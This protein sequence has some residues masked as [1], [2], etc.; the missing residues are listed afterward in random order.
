MIV[1]ERRLEWHRH[2]PR[3]VIPIRNYFLGYQPPSERKWVPQEHWFLL[4]PVRWT[5]G[6]A[7][8]QRSESRTFHFPNRTSQ[9]SDSGVFSYFDSRAG[10]EKTLAGS[11]SLRFMV[12]GFLG[13]GAFE[14]RAEGFFSGL[15][16]LRA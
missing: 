15:G 14:F 16:L 6:R 2:E 5:A 12:L 8:N 9:I 1:L 4:L 3:E 13:F 11:G 10:S 7:R